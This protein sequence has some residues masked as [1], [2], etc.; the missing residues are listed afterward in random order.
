MNSALLRVAREALGYTQTRLAELSGLPQADISR[1]ESGL[2]TPSDEQ[3]GVLAAALDLPRSLLTSDIRPSQPVHR[4]ARVQSKKAERQVD[5]RLEL[6]RIAASNLMRDIDLD[7]PF[8]F[9]TTGDA[10]PADPE[11]AADALRRVWRMPDGPVESLTAYLEAAGALVLRADFGTDDILAAYNHPRGDHRWF[12][13]NTRAHDGARA[14]FSLAHEL[15]HAIL[16]WDRFDAPSDKDAEREAHTFA[17][18]LLMP[19]R[20]MLTA[21]G[22]SRIQLQDLQALRTRWGVSIQA[23]ITRASEL[24]LITATHK[25]RLWKQLSARGWRKSE[26]GFVPLE[27]PRIF[28]GALAIHR[29]DHGYGEGELAEVAGLSQARLSSLLPDYFAAPAPLQVKLSVVK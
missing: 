16:H 17:A 3:I 28:P 27:E 5:G 1:W 8:T 25:T 23:L 9:P 12:F 26:P 21:F 18:A 2:R 11:S 22:G 15:G 14:R 20:S 29:G 13:L 6:A 4:T 10:A 19:R 7:T 24:G